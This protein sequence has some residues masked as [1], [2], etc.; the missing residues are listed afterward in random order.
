MHDYRKLESESVK[1]EQKC[2]L[3]CHLKATTDNAC[4]F[5]SHMDFFVFLPHP[6]ADVFSLIEKLIGTGYNV[7]T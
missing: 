6:V 3:F 1:H 7:S 2:V 4:F 5:A